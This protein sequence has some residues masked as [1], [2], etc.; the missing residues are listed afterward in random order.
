[1]RNIFSIRFFYISRCDNFIFLI[2]FE[3]LF[4]VYEFQRDFKRLWKSHLQ[5]I[6]I[7]I[8]KGAGYLV[9][10]TSIVSFVF[11]LFI[12]SVNSYFTF[13]L[14]N[15]S[16][17]HSFLLLNFCF[18]LIYVLLSLHSLRSVLVWS[19]FFSLFSFCFWFFTFLLFSYI[20]TAL[21]L[22]RIQRG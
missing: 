16:F 10:C 22:E 8:D 12:S 4:L 1:M 6:I 19:L 5:L 3:V 7:S 9:S 2:L 15:S 17:S 20:S 21:K 18:L 14:H 11:C 13:L